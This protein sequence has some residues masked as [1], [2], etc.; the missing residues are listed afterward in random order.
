MFRFSAR[1]SSAEVADSLSKIPDT[2]MGSDTLG[3]AVRDLLAATMHR[4]TEPLGKYVVTASGDGDPE[5]G[6]VALH[7]NITTDALGRDDV[8]GGLN[9]PLKLERDQ[10]PDLETLQELDRR[11]GSGRL[12]RMDL[13]Y[14]GKDARPPGWPGPS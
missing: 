6:P 5:T 14:P 10:L 4:A 13:P 9:L 12:E 3:I 8:A 7:I 2:Q 1:G 11:H